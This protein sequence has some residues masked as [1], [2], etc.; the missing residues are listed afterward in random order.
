M[1]A[2]MR[3]SDWYMNSPIFCMENVDADQSCNT[4]LVC[5]QVNGESLQQ[6]SHKNVV[7]ALR[8]AP[9]PVK[10]TI[11]REKPEKIFTSTEGN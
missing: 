11:L 1:I 8:L 5:L 9:S 7:S 10:L 6:M 3:C 4:A 2:G